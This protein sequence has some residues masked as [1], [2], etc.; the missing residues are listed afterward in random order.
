VEG[1]QPLALQG[2]IHRHLAVPVTIGKSATNP[3][4]GNPGPGGPQGDMGRNRTCDLLI[5]VA[6]GSSF[7]IAALGSLSAVT[8]LVFLVCPLGASVCDCCS[9]ICLGVPSRVAGAFVLCVRVCVC[10]C[11][12]V[13]VCVRERE[14]ERVCV[15]V[16]V[17]VCAPVSLFH[18]LLMYGCDMQTLQSFIKDNKTVL[19]EARVSPDDVLVKTRIMALLALAAHSTEVSFSAVKVCARAANSHYHILYS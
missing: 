13:C 1:R 8:G 18:G 11:V 2:L 12:C 15:C 3:E 19:E 17:C 7:A 10:A 16:C 4:H 14:R 9:R 6:W 5:V